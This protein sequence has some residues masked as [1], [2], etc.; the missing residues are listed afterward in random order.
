MAGHTPGP[1]TFALIIAAPDLLAALRGLGRTYNGSMCFCDMAIGSPM[2]QGHSFAC[3]AAR[4]AIMKA[5][6]TQ[7]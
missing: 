3:I 2:Q 6:G 5:E 1:W 4:N 7:S